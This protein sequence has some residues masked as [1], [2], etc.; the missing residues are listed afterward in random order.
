MVWTR[1]T[2]RSSEAS[3]R[4]SLS[5]PRWL[6]ATWFGAGL[7]P[8]APGSWGS[9]AALPFAWAIAAYGH[10]LLLIPAA[11]ALFGLGWWAASGAVARAGEADPGTVVID[12]VV[13]QWLTLALVPPGLGLYAAGFV[14][15]RLLDVW[16][17]WP[18]RAI[19]RGIGG[20]LGVMAD[21][22][23]AAIIA[24]PLLFVL[25][26]LAEAN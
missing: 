1:A 5:E 25:A 2:P 10:P 18:V 6:I 13:G 8:V 4:P 21:D 11:A 19:D 12:E 16:K 26:R 15:F 22:V 9:A 17:P 23:A 24:A 7:L 3:R 14:L 20:G